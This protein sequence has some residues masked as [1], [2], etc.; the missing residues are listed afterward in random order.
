MHI[1]MLAT[2]FPRSATDFAGQFVFGYARAIVAE[3]ASVT[4]IAPHD[5]NAL[6]HEVVDGVTINRFTYWLPKSAQG[7]CYGAGI[8]TNIRR[9]RW[10]ALQLPFLEAGF[11]AAALRH[12]AQADIYNPH[13]TFAG[14]ATVA[15]SWLN[16][17]PIVT[18]AYSAE[19]VPKMLR[20]PNKLIVRNSDAVI[21]ISQ[22]T[23]DMVEQTIVPRQHHVIGYGV[24]IEKVAPEDFDTAA[25]RQAQGLSPDEIFVFA[26]GRLVERKGYHILIE[27]IAQ[28]VRQGIPV[29]LLLAGTGPERDNL[30]AQIESESIQSAVT[31]LGFIPDADLKN[32]LRA[33]DMLVMPS[34]V[35]QSGDTEGLGIPSL[36]AM[37]NGS[38]VI[39]SDIGGI[40]DIVKHEE[41]GLLVPP[42]DADA[43]AATIMRLTQDKALYEQIVTGGY[44]LVNGQFSW[45]TIA[46]QSLEIFEAALRTPRKGL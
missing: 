45:K 22:F 31:L 36:E 19:Y 28:L 12:G 23:Y 24:N 5:G 27:A 14:L 42:D 26:V 21:S 3:G 46:Q 9:R 10:L 1:C 35:D 43:L 15:A 34:I 40:V 18:T 30:I 13:W 20:Q 6:H 17:K 32:Y 7:L 29:R 25:F 16:R 41:T 2:T 37:I 39:A 33:A 8:P 11:M 4:V 38:P 44:A